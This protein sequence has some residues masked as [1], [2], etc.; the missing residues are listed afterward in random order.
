MNDTHKISDSYRKASEAE[1]ARVNEAKEKLVR[2]SENKL[3]SKF[4]T[5]HGT[6]KIASS[7]TDLKQVAGASTSDIVF[8]GTIKVKANI[9][10]KQIELALP[11]TANAVEF[12]DD[13]ELTALINTAETK[14]AADEIMDIAQTFALQAD[15]TQFVLEDDGSDY[16]KVFHPALD[17]GRELGV[18]S[19][20]EYASLQDKE[21]FFRNTIAD[22]IKNSTLE[23]H[24]DL[25]F[26]G[27]F[28]EPSVQAVRVESIITAADL[29]PKKSYKNRLLEET[30]EKEAEE[31]NVFLSH[32]AN[33]FEQAEQFAAQ[34]TEAELDRVATKLCK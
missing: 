25:S 15:L 5:L 24:Y 21:A 7:E 16:L 22:Q 23:N 30:V 14:T 18:I 26:V 6:G 11:V 10:D 27:S 31:D 2:E 1:S 13:Q 28:S 9:G 19:K 17:S 32:S 34:A 29:E 12:L 20:E 4:Y 33:G 8:T 3:L